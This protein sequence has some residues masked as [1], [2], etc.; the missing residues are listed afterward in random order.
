[1]YFVR[2]GETDNNKNRIVNGGNDD[3]DINEAGIEQAHETGRMLQA[4]NL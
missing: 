3:V 2:H 1:V 4:R